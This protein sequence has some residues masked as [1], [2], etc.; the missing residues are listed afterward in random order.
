MSVNDI[1][2]KATLEKGLTVGSRTGAPSL[3]FGVLSATFV[4]VLNPTPLVTFPAPAAS[5]A[6]CEFP[7]L[8]FPNIFSSRFMGPIVLEKLLSVDGTGFCN[9]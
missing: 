9:R 2:G 3:G 8:R 4:A 7:A 5:N 6:A 1:S